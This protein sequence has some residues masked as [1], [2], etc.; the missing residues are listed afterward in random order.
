MVNLVEQIVRE[1][2]E[3]LFKYILAID[4]GKKRTQKEIVETISVHVG[5]GKVQSVEKHDIMDP[6]YIEQFHLNLDMVPN[7]LIR[8]A[9]GEEGEDAA[10]EEDEEG[11]EGGEKD[12][13]VKLHINSHHLI[14][15]RKV[16]ATT[17]NVFSKSSAPSTSSNHSRSWSPARQIRR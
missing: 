4:N 9:G 10:P 8:G 1:P 2:P 3:D 16:Y 5:T 6:K 15:H 11:E 12:F 14:F 17:S 13:K 7:Q